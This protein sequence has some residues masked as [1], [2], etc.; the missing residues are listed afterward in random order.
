M[1][2]EREGGGVR[3]CCVVC[4][5]RCGVVRCGG[6]KWSG[7]V[8]GEEG[9]SSKRQFSTSAYTLMEFSK[10]RL[11]LGVVSAFSLVQ[12][13]NMFVYERLLST[14]VANVARVALPQTY[15]GWWA[16]FSAQR[17][18]RKWAS[19]SA[20]FWTSG[21]HSWYSNHRNSRSRS[22]MSC[23][24]R[25]SFLHVGAVVSAC[26]FPRLFVVVDCNQLHTIE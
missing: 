14:R 8:V 17:C 9:C 21:I 3:R 6:V 26:T 15:S 5:V 20:P 2:E 24:L 12:D 13:H 7:V 25:T 1:E 23:R 19:F 16:S 18:C 11:K 4:V 22:G 10:C